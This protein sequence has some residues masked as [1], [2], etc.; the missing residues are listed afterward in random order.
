LEGGA[1]GGAPP[2]VSSRFRIEGAK[3]MDGSVPTVVL[4]V[5]V[6]KTLVEVAGMF[7]LGQGILFV[8]AGQKRD[9]NLVYQL[10]RILTRPVFT[11][12]RAVSPRKIVLDRH[13]W[14]VGA[15]V[16]AWAWIILF[17]VKVYLYAKYGLQAT[18]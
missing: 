16:L 12:A 17:V 18:T 10:F 11:L 8:I 15:L 9:S 1:A 2:T 7:M 6:L 4:V 13:L 5:A 14:I 3:C